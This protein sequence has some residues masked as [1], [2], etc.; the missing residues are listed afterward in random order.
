MEG[1]ARRRRRSLASDDE[2]RR[3]SCIGLELFVI[4]EAE[5]EDAA[6]QGKPP[7][8]EGVDE[9]PRRSQPK[10]VTKFASA[11]PASP[12]T[13]PLWRPCPSLRSK[14]GAA[15]V[16]TVLVKPLAAL[17]SQSLPSKLFHHQ[18]CAVE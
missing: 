14:I 16:S 3:V 15:K 5:K 17:P 7:A 1:H 9:S 2:R 12:P 18:I 8:K 4:G 13:G 6:G 11:A 10:P